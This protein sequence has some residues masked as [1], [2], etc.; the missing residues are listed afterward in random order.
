[1]KITSSFLNDLKAKQDE[2]NI[3][4]VLAAL[5]ALESFSINY[6]KIHYNPDESRVISQ[7]LFGEYLSMLSE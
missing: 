6:G 1:M 2:H 3:I 4:N 5:Q 7:E